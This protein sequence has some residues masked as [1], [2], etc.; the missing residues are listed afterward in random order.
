[1][2]LECEN[3]KSAMTKE[4]WTEDLIKKT[5]V[6]SVQGV[7]TDPDFGLEL[8]GEIVKRIKKY[9]Y[10]VPKKLRSLDDVRRKYL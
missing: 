4:K 10:T 2:V 7:L 6:E 9:N 3:M 8:R 1:M 5:V